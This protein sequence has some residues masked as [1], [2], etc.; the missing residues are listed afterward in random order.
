MYGGIHYAWLTWSL[1]LL[2]VWA[3]IY[4]SLRNR[5]SRREMLVVSFWT[6][7][8]G[9]TEPLFVPA[10]WNPPSLFDLAQRTRFDL[11]SLLFSFG[12]GGLAVVAYEWIFPVAHASIPLTE[13]HLPRHRFHVY[14]LLSAPLVFVALL[15]LTRLNPIYAAL[16][17]LFGGGLAGA[18]CRPDLVRKMIVS[19]VLFL[20][21]YFV[22]F[23]T[24]LLVFPN[25]VRLVWNL[26]AISQIFVLGIPIE[27][28][29]FAFFLG[30]LWS[31]VYEH[32]KWQRLTELSRAR[33]A[34]G[35]S[36]AERQTRI[37]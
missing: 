32:L 17:S 5:Q 30:F 13:R 22:Y 25:Y 21:F 15:A 11:E 24:L 36:F 34:T 26:S 31:S 33:K 14:T 18:Y 2:V 12:I 28:L 1:L 19:A 37:Q 23:F 20:S 29:L 10:Y 27:E 35:G 6:S 3:L 7:L 8:L 4:L 16:L 9:L